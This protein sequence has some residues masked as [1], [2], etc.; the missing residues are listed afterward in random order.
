MEVKIKG[1]M[2]LVTILQNRV[3]KMARKIN[4]NILRK[5]YLLA[6][7]KNQNASNFT[8]NALQLEENAVQSANA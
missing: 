8:V 4:Q 2:K 3:T 7:A 1:K 6:I 5:R